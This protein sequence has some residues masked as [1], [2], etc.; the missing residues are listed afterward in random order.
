MSTQREYKSSQG[1]TDTAG[2]RWRG[3]TAAVSLSL[4]LSLSRFLSLSL[5]LSL[6]IPLRLLPLSPRPLSLAAC[7]SLSTPLRAAGFAA[8]ALW[9]FTVAT[10]RIQLGFSSYS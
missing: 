3:K 6:F 1:W 4:S 7:A 9:V 2:R 5:S 8:V 10:A